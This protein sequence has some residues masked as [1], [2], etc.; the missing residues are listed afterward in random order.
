[1]TPKT[2]KA[3]TALLVVFACGLGVFITSAQTMAQ[4]TKSKTTTYEGVLPCADCSGLKTELTLNRNARTSALETYKLR[5]TYLGKPAAPRTSTGKWTI[6]RGTPD[7]PDATVYQLN[8]DKPQEVTNFLVVNDNQIR[9][10]DRDLH[11]IKSTLNFTLTIRGSSVPGGYS[12]TTADDTDIKAAAEFAVAE[13]GRKE[14]VALSLLEIV[15]AQ[16]QVVAG[17]N[18][19]LCLR[20]TSGS[21]TRTAVVVVYK[22][23]QQQYSLTSFQ[24]GNCGM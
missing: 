9:Q 10:L 2:L 20:V 3:R 12:G 6:L 22:N 15:Q 11:E 5:E 19:K 1:M 23:L 17:M 8:P 7:N 16:K 24:W 14:R 18:Y 13:Q 4:P 21:T